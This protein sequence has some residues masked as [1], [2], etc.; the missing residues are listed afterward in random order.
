MLVILLQRKNSWSTLAQARAQIYRRFS[1]SQSLLLSSLSWMRNK[2]TCLQSLGRSYRIARQGFG[3]VLYDS[4]RGIQRDLEILLAAWADF[5]W[6]VLTNMT[7]QVTATSCFITL[8]RT[9]ESALIQTNGLE[10]LHV[11]ETSSISI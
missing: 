9:T 2:S 10:K 6:Q 8:T 4:Q 5:F 3:I 1:M 7:T 11:Q